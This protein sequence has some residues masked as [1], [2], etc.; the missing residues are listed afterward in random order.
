MG[1]RSFEQ[2]IQWQKYKCSGIYVSLTKHNTHRIVLKVAVWRVIRQLTALLPQNY[3]KKLPTP[4][5]KPAQPLKG[6]ARQIP[7]FKGDHFSLQS[8]SK[9]RGSNIGI[10]TYVGSHTETLSPQE[11]SVRTWRKLCR[12]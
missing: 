11:I 2:G 5:C 10:C 9:Q 6:L 1:A 3:K 4:S 8:C 7:K 12:L